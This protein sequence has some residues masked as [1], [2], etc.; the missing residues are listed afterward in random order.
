MGRLLPLYCPRPILLR[1]DQQADMKT[2]LVLVPHRLVR[3][4]S[5][6]TVVAFSTLAFAADKPAAIQRGDTNFCL[7]DLAPFIGK[8]LSEYKPNQ[9]WAAPPRGLQTLGGVPFHIEG[10]LELTGMG[11]A[12]DGRFYPSRLNAIRVSQKGQRIHLLHGTGYADTEGSLIYKLVLHYADGQQRSRYLAYGVHFRNWYLEPSE[13]FSD[14][15]DPNSVVA[16]V[17]SSPDTDRVGAKLRLFRTTL[18]N[19]RPDQEITSIDLVSMFGRA[20]PA[21]VAITLENNPATKETVNDDVEATDE[22]PFRAELAVRVTD[23]QTGAALPGAR[24]K[25]KLSDERQQFAFGEYE[26]DGQGRLVLEYPPRRI[27]SMH[28][29]VSAAGHLPKL[30]AIPRGDDGE[31]PRES[32]VKLDPLPAIRSR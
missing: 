2:D 3:V 9:S 22:S 24:V 8:R 17:G 1:T 13:A 26:G 4:A 15:E 28:L 18:T 10:K 32:G 16:W 11:A 25:L 19:P 29:E 21:I 6:V 23:A 12:R 14:L 30:V 27:V 7:V 5:L 20:T 31:F